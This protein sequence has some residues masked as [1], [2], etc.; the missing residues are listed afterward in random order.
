[1]CLP[2]EADDLRTGGI[3]VNNGQASRPGSGSGG[4][5]V[6]L[7][8]ASAPSSH[9]SC[10]TPTDGKVTGDGLARDCHG[11]RAPVAEDESVGW[12]LHAHGLP[13]AKIYGGSPRDWTGAGRQNQRGQR[14]LGEIE[15][16]GG[17]VGVGIA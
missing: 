12:V 10:A 1:R 6:Q 3:G 9:L 14:R 15:G 11:G 2:G 16:V 5:K 4:G 17:V 7:Q 13:L 8:L